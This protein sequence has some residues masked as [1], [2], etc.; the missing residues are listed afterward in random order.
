MQSRNKR[1]EKDFEAGCHGRVQ[2]VDRLRGMTLC[3]M[4]LYHGMW[5]A[6]YL[7]GFSA[8]WYERWPGALWQQSIC[9]TFLLLS[10]FSYP[11]GRRQG[12][13]GAEVF[14]AGILVSAVTA[15]WMP[16]A[17]VRFGVLTLIGSAM[18]LWYYPHRLL[19]QRSQRCSMMGMWS[20][21]CFSALLFFLFREAAQGYLGFSRLPGLRLPGLRLPGLRLPEAW[22][23]SGFS[24]YLGFP[25]PG[26]Y[27]ADYFPLIPWIFLFSCGY[28]LSRIW[29]CFG[30]PGRRYRDSKGH[31]FCFLG[32]HSLLIYLL[33]QPIILFLFWVGD[34]GRCLI[35]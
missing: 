30:R 3:S 19:E 34:T 29:E 15:V 25:M 1:E 23:R 33:H 11:M 22:Y 35:R 21:V 16:E 14:L 2:W 6:V 18:L 13:R 7:F 31:L 17:A 27:S 4:M 9:W 10:G 28:F 12:R 20:G 24:T 32:R 8:P 5:D 26:F